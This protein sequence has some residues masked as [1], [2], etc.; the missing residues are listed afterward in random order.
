MTLRINHMGV[1]KFALVDSNDDG[2]LV[3]LF[4]IVLI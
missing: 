1:H 2:L 3:S 4:D